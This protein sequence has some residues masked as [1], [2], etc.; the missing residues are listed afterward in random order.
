M[1]FNPSCLAPGTSTCADGSGRLPAS[2]L[3]AQELEEL[4]LWVG[5]G[6][7]ADET[8]SPVP[9]RC[10]AATLSLP[11]ARWP[12]GHL[13]PLWHML[14]FPDTT[15]TVELSDDGTPRDLALLPPI[16]AEQILW[17]GAE[18]AFTAPLAVGVVTQRQSR[19][20]AIDAHQGSRG[21]MIFVTLEHRYLQ[22]GRLHVLEQVRLA[23]L[24][25][26]LSDAS[27]TATLVAG[28]SAPAASERHWPV[29]EA[30]L[31][32]FSALTFNAHRI[33]Y[34]APYVTGV[35]HYPGLVV[36]GPLQ[37]MLM[38]ETVRAEAPQRLPRRAVF[39]ARTPLFC[40]DG[41][42]CVCSDAPKGAH[43]R[44]LWTRAAHGGVAMEARFEF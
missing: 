29:N 18:Y 28:E 9:S 13:P 10:L 21:Q 32:R 14:H 6:E 36:Q 42:V 20:S 30:L 27:A 39:R 4:R 26:A 22:R 43:E 1:P 35:A 8:L 17:T 31:F 40:T 15:P 23:F 37:A 38:A 19:V 33:H 24:P 25:A 16:D 3:A 11:G 41:Q 7:S 2:G 44:T 12:A 34:D 5:R